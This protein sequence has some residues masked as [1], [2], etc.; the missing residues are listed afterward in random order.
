MRIWGTFYTRGQ[1]HKGK[2]WVVSVREI[3]FLEKQ[4]S[5]GP[6]Q[7]GWILCKTKLGC[8]LFKDMVR[9][10]NDCA[11]YLE[12]GERVDNAYHRHCD[13][14]LNIARYQILAIPR[15]DSISHLPLPCATY[16]LTAIIHLG[17]INFSTL[18]HQ[19]WWTVYAI[20]NT[21]ADAYMDL[22][23]QLEE[24]RAHM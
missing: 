10:S 7:N 22:K 14:G 16:A 23:H 3:S 12:L 20:P 4:E 17:H 19:L 5:L 24:A 8:P 15:C 13:N 21:N 2:W 11:T 6:Q 9:S 1:R 18:L